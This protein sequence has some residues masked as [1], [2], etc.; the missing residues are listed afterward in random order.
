MFIMVEKS[1]MFHGNAKVGICIEIL[2]YCC[3]Q[4]MLRFFCYLI[5]RC[6]CPR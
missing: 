5:R 2:N 3:R 4:H 1:K 6:I